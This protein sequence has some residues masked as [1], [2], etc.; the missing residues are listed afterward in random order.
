ML[1][2]INDMLQKMGNMIELSGVKIQ[3]PEGVEHLK[4]PDIEEA[5]KWVKNIYNTTFL[6]AQNI[7]SLQ[8]EQ[9]WESCET[10]FGSELNEYS[11]WKKASRRFKESFSKK[12]NFFKKGY[13]KAHVPKQ[14]EKGKDAQGNTEESQ[15]HD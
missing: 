2:S 8:S 11:Q 14:R 7:R 10:F 1:D 6:K 5:Y 15:K 13:V 12:P 9:Y 3:V 4:R